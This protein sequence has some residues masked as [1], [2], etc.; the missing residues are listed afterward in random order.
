MRAQKAPILHTNGNFAPPRKTPKRACGLY[1]R[2]TPKRACGYAAG[3]PL[4]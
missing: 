1:P 3:A 4:G 2:K